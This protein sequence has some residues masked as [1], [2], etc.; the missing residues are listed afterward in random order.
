M[1][2]ALDS[3]TEAYEPFYNFP[4]PNNDYYA[5]IAVCGS[6]TMANTI[7]LLYFIGMAVVGGEG[8]GG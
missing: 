5:I 6:F 2:T 8:G 3:P 1:H 4:F 7:L